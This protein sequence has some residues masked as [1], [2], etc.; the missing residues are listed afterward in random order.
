MVAGCGKRVQP[1]KRCCQRAAACRAAPVREKGSRVESVG[2][3]RLAEE[4]NA[5]R[6][7]RVSAVSNL[8]RDRPQLGG[9]WTGDV[10][11]PIAVGPP[12]NRECFCGCGLMRK[13]AHCRQGDRCSEN[14]AVHVE[15]PTLNKPLTACAE[16]GD[17]HTSCASFFSSDGF[18]SLLCIVVAAIVRTDYM[19]MTM[20][21]RLLDRALARS[22]GCHQERECGACPRGPGGAE[23]S[24]EIF[25]FRLNI[26]DT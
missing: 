11:V 13:Q 14:L 22:F 1:T 9:Y 16:R 18:D 19:S 6:L 3:R 15:A 4:I 8:K 24:T 23:L 10:D 17:F 21:L 2:S 5:P 7:E 26:F 12:C 25:Q 20:E